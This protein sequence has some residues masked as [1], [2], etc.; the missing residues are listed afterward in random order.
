MGGLQSK[1]GT[2]AE[3]NSEMK[4]NKNMLLDE[5]PVFND[6]MFNIM[7]TPGKAESG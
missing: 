2:F 5:M 6:K 4:V 3:L 7:L 1:A